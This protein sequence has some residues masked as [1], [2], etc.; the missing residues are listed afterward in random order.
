MLYKNIKYKLIF[1]SLPNEDQ[2]YFESIIFCNLKLP[3]CLEIYYS[4]AHLPTS[5]DFF[6][7]MISGQVMNTNHHFAFLISHY[8]NL[9][10]L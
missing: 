2:F 6:H 1:D 8:I 5:P 3:G 9:Y 7:C 4:S 10:L